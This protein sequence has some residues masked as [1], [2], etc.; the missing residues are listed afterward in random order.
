MNHFFD[1]IQLGSIKL[2]CL[3]AELKSFTAAA[4]TA[5]VTPAA[6][7]RSIART[8][9]RLGVRLFVR[10]TRQI[11]LTDAGQNYYEH[12][13]QALAQLMEAEN[14]V[15]KEQKIP[16]GI[17][18]ISVP[19]PY[20]H[21]RLLPMLPLFRQ[22][23]PSISVDV[24][25]SNQ[26]VDFAEGNYDLSI[27]GNILPDS[28][29]IA[30]KLEDAELIIVAAP[31][32]LKQH[33]QPTHLEELTK[34][35]CIQFELPSTGRKAPWLFQQNGTP[36]KLSTSGHYTCQ[37]DFLATQTL[38]KSGAGLMQVYRFAV[39]EELKKG[40]LIEV[41]TEFGG[42]TRPF[43]LIYPY[44]TYIPLKVRVFIEFLFENQM[45]K[46]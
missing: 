5:G 27:R 40:E 25:I 4:Y 44:S 34:H 35:E 9:E 8:E 26:N 15:M 28:N 1:D 36:I 7:S 37:D 19:T 43:M 46:K 2:F 14:N 13:H 17:L 20:A 30:R 32:Y 45:S 3:A 42:S 33:G 21:Y 12:C 31:D 41:L 24:H 22:R 18:R 16:S 11:R 10:T 6:V 29:L 23:Y 39:E 38:A